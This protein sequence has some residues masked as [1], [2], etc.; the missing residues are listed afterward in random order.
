MER[1]ES[2]PGCTRITLDLP[3]PLYE[4]VMRFVNDRRGTIAM[5]QQAGCRFL[6]DDALTRAG[7]TATEDAGAR[8]GRPRKR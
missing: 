3:T 5:S 8:T 7:Y 2:R 6:L 4:R 1:K